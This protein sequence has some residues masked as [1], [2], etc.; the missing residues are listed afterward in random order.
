M[1]STFFS[2]YND[3]LPLLET[4]PY[5]QKEMC[6]KIETS[7]GRYSFGLSKALPVIFKTFP[8]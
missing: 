6:F 1:V 4:T 3:Y 2:R 5:L 7:S 8:Q